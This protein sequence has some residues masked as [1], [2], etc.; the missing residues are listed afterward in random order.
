MST[1]TYLAH[2]KTSYWISV[3]PTK[4]NIRTLFV[5]WNLLLLMYVMYSIGCIV[6]M[7]FVSTE[8]FI[9]S[10]MHAFA[11]LDLHFLYCF[12]FFYASSLAL[13][14]MVYGVHWLFECVFVSTVFLYLLYF[15]YLSIS[16]FQLLIC[17]YLLI[18]CVFLL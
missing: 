7:Y 15:L 10:F 11:H 12:L 6:C 4:S 18:S 17:V 5:H 8:R 3:S 2:G 13:K 16:V 14:W 9:D 1:V